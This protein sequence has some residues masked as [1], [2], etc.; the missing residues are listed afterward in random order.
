MPKPYSPRAELTRIVPIV[1]RR[2]LIPM[3]YRLLAQQALGEICGSDD[4]SKELLDA[5]AEDVRE[6]VLA[7]RKH[8]TFYTGPPLF[9]GALMEWFSSRQPNLLNS[10]P[11]VSIDGRAIC[12]SDALQE[13]R[14]RGPHLQTKTLDVPG[15]IRWTAAIEGYSLE[16]HV[17]EW[18]RVRYPAFWKPAT[19]EGDFT[20]PCNHDFALHVGKYRLLVDVMGQLRTGLYGMPPGKKPANI[21]LISAMDGPGAIIYGYK[22]R[23]EIAL[24]ANSQKPFH[25]GETQQLS[26]L[27][28][29][30]NCHAAGI[31]YESARRGAEG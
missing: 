15:Y 6:K 14:R 23:S 8:G 16:K 9:S 25:P 29:W 4:I 2:K 31:D 11:P 13:V 24:V 17:S 18:F 1:L 20:R 26:H 10:E 12:W 19:N 22:D 21:H 30:L 3:H 27:L 5:A 7:A 28:V